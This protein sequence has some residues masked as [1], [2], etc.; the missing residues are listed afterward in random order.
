MT[1]VFTIFAYYIT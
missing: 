1:I